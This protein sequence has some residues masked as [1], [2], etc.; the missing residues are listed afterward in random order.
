MAHTF[1][2][3]NPGS[4]SLNSGIKT[5]SDDPHT[6]HLADG[7]NNTDCAD[8]TLREKFKMIAPVGEDPLDDPTW[9]CPEI[10][11][12]IFS[13]I[14]VFGGVFIPMPPYTDTRYFSFNTIRAY[15]KLIKHNDG[16]GLIK[17]VSDDS[18][19]ASN[20]SFIPSSGIIGGSGL[21]A[22]LEDSDIYIPGIR[23]WNSDVDDAV[24]FEFTASNSDIEFAGISYDGTNIYTE[25]RDAQNVALATSTD[26]ISGYADLDAIV[27]DWNG[28]VITDQGTWAC[29]LESGDG[30]IAASDLVETGGLLY[31]L[32]TEVTMTEASGRVATVEIT[33]DAVTQVKTMT[34]RYQG[35]GKALITTSYEL[36]SALT[37]TLSDLESLLEG[38]GVFWNVQV[39][40]DTESLSN[41]LIVTS[42]TDVLGA[43]NLAVIR[44]KSTGSIMKA[45]IQPTDQIFISDTSSLAYGR[46]MTVGDTIDLKNGTVEILGGPP[47]DK[48]LFNLESEIEVI[49]TRSA[50][51]YWIDFGQPAIWA[52]ITPNTSSATIADEYAGTCKFWR[53]MG[54]NVR[55]TDDANDTWVYEELN[56]ERG[57][58][59][60]DNYRNCYGCSKV[61]SSNQVPGSAQDALANYNKGADGDSGFDDWVATGY[62]RLGDDMVEV[63]GCAG[64]PTG[65]T[66][67]PFFENQVPTYNLNTHFS[68]LMYGE[69]Q[70][71]IQNSLFIPS[72]STQWRSPYSFSGLVGQFPDNNSYLNTRKRI[73]HVSGGVGTLTYDDFAEDGSYQKLFSQSNEDKDK[74]IIGLCET[75]LGNNRN[76]PRYLSIGMDPDHVGDGVRGDW[77]LIFDSN[78]LSMKSVPERSET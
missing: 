75:V 47:S 28:K 30:T 39:E 73:V 54:V 18:Y 11:Q 27:A 72:F 78:F 21:P 34:L 76:L 33:E 5:Y 59:G 8:C 25:Y 49:I 42:Q 2:W 26:A 58:N 60:Y 68:D 66:K 63:K 10:W 48:V 19:G 29:T 38:L 6:C 50:G 12:D 69:W 22:S 15:G 67:C 61:N 4:T 17:F 52:T 31:A 14:R 55:Y 13:M 40:A 62:I 20:L 9:S 7:F 43:G 57:S 77:D 44:I 36:T 3:R 32:D 53:N 23:I 16:D 35:Q 56:I 46:T 45:P 24:S 37:E 1:E 41:N 51:D 70:V 65:P 74:T 64:G 71:Q